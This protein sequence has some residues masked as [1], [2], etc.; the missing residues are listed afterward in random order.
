MSLYILGL[1][2]SGKSAVGKILKED[3]GYEIVDF[4]EILSL[5]TGK[6][7]NGILLSNGFAVL[8]NLEGRFLKRFKKFDDKIIVTLGLVTDKKLYSGKIV[9]IKVPKEKF[10]KRI[11][12]VSKKFRDLDKIYEN[13]HAIFSQ[14]SDL[15]ISSENKTKFDVAKIIDN[16]YRK[17]FKK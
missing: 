14:N 9:Y 3:F 8:R 12:K 4:D 13:F 16:F 5:E 10:V 6:S 2:G 11:H 15:V 1:P 17:N 7:F